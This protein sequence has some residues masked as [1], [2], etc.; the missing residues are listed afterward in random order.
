MKGEAIKRKGKLG[1]EEGNQGVEG[2]TDEGPLVGMRQEGQEWRQ[3][4]GG[5]EGEEGNGREDG[6]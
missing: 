1:R 6:R 5:K 4:P 2:A 3:R